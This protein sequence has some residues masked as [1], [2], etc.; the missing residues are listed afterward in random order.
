[1]KAYSINAQSTSTNV[2]IRDLKCNHIDNPIGFNLEK[3]SL[4]WVV[5]A[6]NGTVQSQQVV[7][8]T[9]CDMKTVVYESPRSKTIRSI[10]LI[11]SLQLQPCTRYYWLVRVWT[12]TETISSNLAWFETAKMEQEWKAEWITSPFSQEI[13]PIMRKQFSIKRCIKFARVYIC[14]LGLYKFEINGHKVGN[15][16]LT[17]YCNAY[18]KWLQYQTFDVTDLLNQGENA[19]GVM[20]GNGWYKGRFGFAGQV[21]GYY[22]NAFALLCE[23][24]IN[25]TDGSSITIGSDCNWKI[26]RS[27]VIDSN[28][29]DG[30]AQDMTRYISGWSCASIE[31]KNWIE[32][33]PIDIGYERLEARR[34]IP[35]IIKEKR[36]PVRLIH[37]PQNETVLDMGQNM[38]GWVRF[39]TSAPTG[40][41]ITLQYGEELQN[42]CF[43]RDNLRT[44]KAE[45]RYISNGNPLIAEPNFTFYGFRYV[46]VTGWVGELNLED[47]TGCVVY[48]DLKQTGNISTSNPL[49]NQLFMN[50]L[51]GQK[52]NFLDV[53]TDCPQ[54]D[55]RM[56][57]TG[58]AQVFS[59]TAC[60]NMDVSAFFDK[61]LYDLSKEQ[62]A[63]GGRVP[64]I[65][66]A[67]D[68][69]PSENNPFTA[70][71]SCA[72]GDAATII[73][74]NVYLH[75]GN[76]SMLSRQFESMKAW[77][78]FIR[79]QD[80][81]DR[82][83]KT[84][85]HFGDWLALDGSNPNSPFGGT[86]NDYVS[87]AYYRYS[88][89]L[90]AKAAKVL[91]KHEISEEYHRLSNEVK[92][93]IQ[94]EFFTPNGRLA[95]DTQTAYVL[96]L[97]MDLAPHNSKDRMVRALVQNLQAH[98][99]HLTTG[100]VGT[101][102]LCHVLSANGHNDLAYRLLLNDD[103]PSWLYS[104][105]LGATTIWERWNSLNLDGTFGDKGMNSL[106]HYAYG[107][108][109]E[110][111]YRVVCGINPVED[112]PGYSCVRLSPKPYGLLRWAKATFDS[113]AGT[114][115]SGWEIREDVLC[116]NFRI[117]FECRADL[118]LP[119]AKP[120]NII[121]NDKPLNRRE[122]DV[123]QKEDDV[124][125]TL[126][127]GEYT[128]SYVPTK[129]Y[130]IKFSS[131]STLSSLLGNKKAKAILARH[132]PQ[133]VSGDT[134][135]ALKMIGAEMPF[136]DL[137][138][139]MGNVSAR[140]LRILD[141][142]LVGIYGW[143]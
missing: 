19:I 62:L 105:K 101:P 109:V 64:N 125:L 6:A 59:G 55:E 50:A 121:M 11:P 2:K 73:P 136:S 135:D 61:Y 57:W 34:S 131:R 137:L 111:M 141:D 139:Y 36:K 87:S 15:E 132:I 33:K 39:V 95:I 103:F 88:S 78:D 92:D 35:V 17:P 12:D 58:D 56:G 30:E 48:S 53:P 69:V 74:W 83:W 97:Y 40:T 106:N 41:E 133:V 112:A 31:D 124:L 22:G 47:F 25:Y 119:D 4:S 129:E 134:A 82:L 123:C 89:M 21:G 76:L 51:W 96:A 118:R 75:F 3:P 5:E 46:K 63:N 98:N 138:P 116:F 27:Y 38:V 18:D 43:C 16:Y 140:T 127:E 77:V 102:Y 128:I 91:G 26:A 113:S 99:N 68:M 142:E 107:S 110:W 44:A 8:S 94:K 23:I 14:G 79:T 117:P 52:G 100:F 42:G 84:G 20:L 32:A 115:E 45:F 93:A 37:T 130:V 72:W 108:I 86:P 67:F 28:I 13:H 80:D 1:M 7:I 70:G 24:V 104:I 90:V 126:S 65:V 60:F 29:Y 114:I 71:G 54:R 66:P 49:V 143:N 122:Y 10:G 81:G 9:D 85:F 120:E